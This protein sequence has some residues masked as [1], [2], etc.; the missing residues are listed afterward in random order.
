[1]S[2]RRQNKT[3]IINAVENTFVSM[4]KEMPFDSFS[5][6]DLC[7]RAGVGR[8]SF[9]RYYSSKEDVVMS[10]LLH[11]WN[12][13]C[14]ADGI[15]IHAIISPDTARAFVRHCYDYKEIFDLIYRNKLDSLFPLLV[16]KNHGEQPQEYREIFFCYGVFGILH[17]WW[18]RGYKDPLENVIHTLDSLS[19]LDDKIASK[20]NN[21]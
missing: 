2:L 8:S 18:K 7:E 21:D 9:Y 6:R 17:E 4:L 20:Q 10:F 11:I 3:A 14:D 19:L 13:W 1:M 15:H 16:E 12:V 5:I